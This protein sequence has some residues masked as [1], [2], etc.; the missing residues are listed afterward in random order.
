MIFYAIAR[1]KNPGIYTEWNIAKKQVIGFPNAKYKKFDTSNEAQKF[2]D[3]T[4]ISISNQLLDNFFKINIP[5]ESDN[6]LIC[7][8]DGSCIFNGKKNAKSSFGI[9]WPYHEEYNYSQIIDGDSH[10]NNIG[11]YTALIYAFKQADLIDNTNL[12]TLICYTDSMLL[13]KSLTEWLLNWKKN[14]WRKSD[15]QIILNLELIKTLD[16][17]MQTRKLILRHVKAH[18]G[19]NNWESINNDKVDKLA[20]NILK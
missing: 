7:F 13:I 2:I 1:G 4:P 11:E 17:Y 3:N 20:K 6:C 12:K 16:K 8:T 19:K 5:N 10:T 15:N 14:N 9:I 18:T